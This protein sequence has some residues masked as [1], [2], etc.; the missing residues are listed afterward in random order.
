MFFVL[1]GSCGLVPS[2]CCQAESGS[3][4]MELM[5][6]HGDYFDVGCGNIKAALGKIPIYV[7]GTSKVLL[8]NRSHLILVLCYFNAKGIFARTTC[9]YPSMSIYVYIYMDI[10]VLD[11][12][13]DLTLMIMYKSYRIVLILGGCK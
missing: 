10:G 6:F 5:H 7:I 11:G 4:T 13:N 3:L 2:S 12:L 8:V 9:I 1:F